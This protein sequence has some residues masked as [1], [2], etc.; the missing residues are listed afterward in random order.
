MRVLSVPEMSSPIQREM[1]KN[2]PLR[3]EGPIRN[4]NTALAWNYGAVV[5]PKAPQPAGIWTTPD[6]RLFTSVWPQ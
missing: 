3:N 4:Y 1:K 5:P 6:S 2:G